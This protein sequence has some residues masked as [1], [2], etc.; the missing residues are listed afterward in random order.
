[1]TGSEPPPPLH[2]LPSL[3]DPLQ[4][5]DAKRLGWNWGG[6]L[7]PYLWLVGHGRVTLGL[8]LLLSWSIPLVGWLNLVA[9]PLTG[10]YLGLNG[11]T[12]AWRHQPYHD[13]E[14]L[15]EREREWAIWGFIGI[16]LLVV[17]AAF[18]MAFLAPVYRDV[19]DGMGGMGLIE[20]P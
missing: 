2:P 18:F 8:L 7:L 1:M 13:L 10:F 4:L 6:F 11:F 14:Q 20:G 5:D 9:Y 15:R 17:G 16:V 19:L 3:N 12:V